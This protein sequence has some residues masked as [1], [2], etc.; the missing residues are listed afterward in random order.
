M[1]PF[2]HFGA[3]FSTPLPP[4]SPPSTKRG[5]REQ[6]AERRALRD[7]QPE[8][9]PN[10]SRDSK[11]RRGRRLSP[12]QEPAVVDS[13]S[14][15]TGDVSSGSDSDSAPAATAPAATAPAATERGIL[16]D[17]IAGV[18]SVVDSALNP[19]LGGQSSTAVA[20]PEK[21]S[22][23]EIES[24][25]TPVATTASEPEAVAITSSKP[26]PDAVETSRPAII[27]TTPTEHSSKSPDA[28]AS[29]APPVVAVA[30]TTG[31]LS[32]GAAA[33]PTPSNAAQLTRFN[34]EFTRA[35]PTPTAQLQSADRIS[36]SNSQ[37]T[38]AAGQKAQGQAI[39][40]TVNT[41]SPDVDSDSDSDGIDSGVESDDELDSDDEAD[42]PTESRLVAFTTISGT[43]L[44]TLSAVLDPTAVRNLPSS[45]T[46]VSQTGGQTTIA[47][48]AANNKPSPLTPEA[49]N[50]LI[51]FG[52]VGGVLLLSFV[53]YILLRLR[54]TDA[55]GCF[56]CCGSKRKSQSNASKSLYHASGVFGT[57]APSETQTHSRGFSA[58][59]N[60][61]I[62]LRAA[63]YEK[64][65]SQGQPYSRNSLIQNAAPIAVSQQPMPSRDDP[66][67]MPILPPA[68]RQVNGK[69][70][71]MSEVSSL[72]SGFGDAVIDIPESGPTTTY[73]SNKSAQGLPKPNNQTLGLDLGPRFS[74]A[75]VPTPRTL[76]THRNRD[77]VNTATT[78]TSRDSEPRFRTVTSWVN[79]QT[80]RVMKNQ[81]DSGASSVSSQERSSVP[82]VPAVPEAYGGGK[83]QRMPSAETDVVFRAHPGDEVEIKES[84]RIPSTLLT[85]KLRL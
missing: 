62:Q 69:N 64:D 48:A 84:S 25:S 71:R 74:W 13:D 73:L 75:N 54:K 55:F 15:S 28:P 81:G 23:A 30:G 8:R 33:T 59:F 56:S 52:A 78:T 22:A 20:A 37:A 57:A 24:K 45:V 41:T 83:H 44:S 6:R 82:D 34:P 46:P 77:T 63:E 76:G 58:F 31:V 53:V 1:A 12:R 47:S 39:D 70:P 9:A 40:S 4:V 16:D 85:R 29:S 32:P 67:P 27:T 7:F 5:V 51:A 2:N 49:S 26:S 36:L 17:A 61:M 72:S 65:T 50:G 21:T 3:V 14:D 80:N 66:P 35:F 43:P 11:L 38:G 60:P 68:Y 10:T 79:Q 19:I 18:G 42:E